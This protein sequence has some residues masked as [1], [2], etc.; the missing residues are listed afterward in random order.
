[1]YC[2]KCGAQISDSAK[3]C[4]KCGTAVLKNANQ[5]IDNEAQQVVENQNKGQ[6]VQPAAT[7]EAQP[8]GPSIQMTK[9]EA[10]VQPG[11]QPAVTVEAQS[12]PVMNVQME[13]ET[14]AS[15]KKIIPAAILL[16]CILGVIGGSLFF[17]KLKNEKNQKAEASVGDVWGEALEDSD[18]EADE[19]K[20]ESPEE[21]ETVETLLADGK[22]YLNEHDFFNAKKCYESAIALD[23]EDESVYLYGADVYLSQGNYNGAI[24]VLNAGIEIS[25]SEELKLRKDYVAANVVMKE[26]VSNYY[27][28]IN[29]EYDEYGNLIQDAY[30]TYAY[31]TNGKLIEETRYDSEGYFIEKLGYKYDAQGL[32][33]QKMNYT[34][35]GT[36]LG[37]T[38]Y[39]YA[40]G[41]KIVNEIYYDESGAI[42]YW[43]GYAYSDE[44][45]IEKKIYHESDGDVAYWYEYDAAGNQLREIHNS[46][47]G[48]VNWWNELVY[49]ANGN[50][51]S[52][53][54]YNYRGKINW[55]GEY[56]Y[57]SNGNRVKSVTYNRDDSI[58]DWREH[59]Y[60]NQG[61]LVKSSSHKNDGTPYWWVEYTYDADGNEIKYAEYNENGIATSWRETE[62]TTDDDGNTV[63]R[64]YDEKGQLQSEKVID[65]MGLVSRET[66]EGEECTYTYTYIGDILS[67]D[68]VS[69]T[70]G[71]L[72]AE[73]NAVVYMRRVPN[74][75]AAY[76]RT[77]TGGSYQVVGETEEFYRLADGWY[78]E[79]EQRGITYR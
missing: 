47:D 20:T 71:T 36:A 74:K 37:W 35:D 2:R 57:D 38:Q 16:V 12:Q 65:P 34:E 26:Q 32:L 61:R 50:V 66:V 15:K 63:I 76:V 78:V 5:T 64:V 77:E 24:E 49:D 19:E 23:A 67:T 8:A 6:A 68:S 21:I 52:E 11:P 41:G 10:K 51:T 48:K 54:E 62:Y 70:E 75:Q 4:T 9:E 7:A 79:K 45:F 29:C 46:R 25:D 40:G 60:D 22:N 59:V 3:F 53:V 72:Q 28:T 1:M 27:G 30:G 39:E 33:I 13:E 17:M 73:E 69:E 55:K 31:D 56:V 43:F 42:S 58:S 14:D 18:A 44:G